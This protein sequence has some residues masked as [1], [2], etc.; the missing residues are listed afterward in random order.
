MTRSPARS[1][2][3]SRPAAGHAARR[4]L[5]RHRLAA[6]RR[7]D[8]E[9]AAVDAPPV[10]GAGR[11]R[12]HR[13]ADGGRPD[14]PLR[15]GR[16]RGRPRH[17]AAAARA[18]PVRRRRGVRRHARVEPARRQLA[19]RPAGLRRPGGTRRRRL[20]HGPR[21]PPGRTVDQAVIDAAAA[22]ALAPFERG[23]RREPL[24]PPPGD[25]AD[26]ERPRRHHPQGGGD[27]ARRSPRLEE[28]KD[29]AQ[30]LTVE[31]HRQFNPGWHL[32]L[33][34]RNMLARQRVRRP[35]G[36]AAAG[37]PR[38]AHPR[39]LPG[40]WTRPGGRSCSSAPWTA[41]AGQGRGAADAADARRP[42]RRCSRR[43]S[44]RSTSP[45]KSSRRCRRRCTSDGS[46][47]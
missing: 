26:D 42:D 9:A 46:G 29:R 35:G 27:R 10:Q 44:W 16:C 6:Q 41:T 39:R 8:H 22:A 1:T 37:E 31:G 2:P 30:H 34:L 12:H 36:A 3:R 43:T 11:R 23:G 19:V 24:H 25:A 14:L 21:R 38:R 33:D 18:G 47:S 15:H 7:G 28:L 40:A 4:R 20:R 13:G 32:A 17:R 5:P 45:P